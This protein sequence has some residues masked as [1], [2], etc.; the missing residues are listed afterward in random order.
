MN[1]TPTAM[2]TKAPKA[3]MTIRVIPSGSPKARN[4][5]ILGTQAS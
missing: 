2:V 5:M 3:E 1:L 4:S